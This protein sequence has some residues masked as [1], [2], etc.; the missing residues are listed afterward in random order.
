MLCPESWL[1]W[2]RVDRNGLRVLLE[3]LLD[4]PIERVL[5]SHGDPV[6]SGGVEAL[7]G[8]LSS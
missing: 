2:V 4:L 5:V 3:P 6:L 7:R 8:C 1:Y